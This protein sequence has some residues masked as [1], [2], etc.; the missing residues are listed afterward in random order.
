MLF[1]NNANMLNLGQSAATRSEPHRRNWQKLENSVF[2]AIVDSVHQR[3]DPCNHLQLRL[4]QLLRTPIRST[5]HH[6][7]YS[8]P[9]MLSGCLPWLHCAEMVQRVYTTTSL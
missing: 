9:S 4:S 2:L 8:C 7:F 5:A 3:S 1:D 6:R